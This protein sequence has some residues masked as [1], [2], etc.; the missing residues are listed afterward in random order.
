MKKVSL[1]VV[2]A[3]FDFSASAQLKDIMRNKVNDKLNKN[4]KTETKSASTPSE[5]STTATPADTA[6][7]ATTNTAPTNTTQPNYNYGSYGAANKAGKSDIA[8]EYNFQHNVHMELES[9]EKG[10]TSGTKNNMIVYLAKDNGNYSGV[11]MKMDPKKPADKIVSVYEYDKKQTV[12]YM[13]NDGKKYVR[14]SKYEATVTDTAKAS[15][16]KLTKTGR[17]KTILNYKC[18]EWTGVDSK[19]GSKYEMWITNDVNIPVNDYIRK[20]AQAQSSR[21]RNNVDYS[22]LPKGLMMEM[23]STDKEGNKTLL[24]VIAINKD[25]P[26]TVKTAD[27]EYMGF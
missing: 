14:V 19:N 16:F 9:I 12:M 13:N 22:N 8:A 11:E 21:G 2:C 10:A 25:Q 20:N 5:N 6:K 26:F 15:D 4:T 27:Y 1:L 18:E 17:T 3:F 24:K 23:T 7:P